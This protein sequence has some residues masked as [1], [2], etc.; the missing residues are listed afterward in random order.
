MSKIKDFLLL[1][2][3]LILVIGG[4]LF[5]IS[6]PPVAQQYPNFNFNLLIASRS[7]LIFLGGVSM[8]FFIKTEDKKKKK[9]TPKK[10]PP[11]NIDVV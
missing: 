8:Y 9:K 6:I 10:K 2:I 4:L 3:G 5:Y 11:S 1:L 7:V